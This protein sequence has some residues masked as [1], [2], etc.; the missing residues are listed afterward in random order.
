MQNKILKS[1]NGD[2]ESFAN[3][4]FTSFPSKLSSLHQELP[5][6]ILIQYLNRNHF[7]FNRSLT[8]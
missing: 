6:T 8:L 3:Y 4:Y 5:I 7:N 2:S 1:L